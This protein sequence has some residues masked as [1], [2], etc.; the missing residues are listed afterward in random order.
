MA[1][2]SPE[3]KERADLAKEKKGKVCKWVGGRGFNRQDHREDKKSHKTD[4]NLGEDLK[5]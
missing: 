3:S 5:A 1:V 2:I 4:K